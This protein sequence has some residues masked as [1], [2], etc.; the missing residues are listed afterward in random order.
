MAVFIKKLQ[1][2]GTTAP[3]INV[4]GA[5]VDLED[6]TKAVTQNFETFYNA[7][8]G[9]WNKDQEQEAL[10]Q[11]NQFVNELSNG[12]ITNYTGPLQ[13]L[14]GDYQQYA[15]KVAQVVGIYGKQKEKRRFT[16]KSIMQDFYN[17][18]FGGS[19]EPDFQSFL[20]LDEVVTDASGQK[21]RGVKN[22]VNALLNFLNENYLSKY[23]DADESLGGIEGVRYKIDRL[24]SALADGK[25][26][27]EDYAAASALGFNLRGLLSGMEQNVSQ[28]PN[29]NDLLEEIQLWESRD[30]G[31]F[32]LN[33][34][35][36]NPIES[37]EFLQNYFKND[38]QKYATHLSNLAKNLSDN[39]LS[40]YT[41]ETLS[42]SKYVKNIPDGTF[43][44]SMLDT[45]TNFRNILGIPTYQDISG[46]YCVLPNSFDQ[47]KGTIL[48]YYPELKVLKPI[49]IW[50]SENKEL[51][52]SYYLRKHPELAQQ[53]QKGQYG[54]KVSND[55]PQYTSAEQAFI[56]KYNTSQLGG[57]P[58]TQEQE[59][60][61]IM[62]Q[63]K[64][65]Q[66]VPE[67]WGKKEWAE[68]VSIASSLAA[69]ADPEPFSAA[70]LGLNGTLFHAYN[71]ANDEDGF[72]LGDAG[73]TL[74]N[75]GFDV[76]GAIPVLGDFAQ[77]K[78]ITK[79]I[80][81]LGAPLLGIMGATQIP[82]A[83]ES[84]SKLLKEGTDK[85][86]VQDWRN[87][88]NGLMS[89]LGAKNYWT[90][91]YRSRAIDNASDF[92][93]KNSLQQAQYDFHSILRNAGKSTGK[94][95]GE[96]TSWW[97]SFKNSLSPTKYYEQKFGSVPKQN[98]ESPS[99]IWETPDWIKNT[100][101]WIKKTVGFK[102]SG[103][104]MK[105][106]PGGWFEN[107]KKRYQQQSLT[108]WDTT[109]DQSR[110]GQNLRGNGHYN[111]G[112]LQEAYNRNVAYIDDFDAVGKDLQDY[113]NS[114][115]S[116]NSLE[117]YVNNYNSDI[118]KLTGHW[119]T[120]RIYGSMDARDHNRLFRSMYTRRSSQDSNS[121]YNIG[122]QDDIE[123]IEGSSAWLRRADNYENLWDKTSL[124]DKLRRIHKIK[125]GNG[126]EG[127]VYKENNGKIGIIGEQQVKDLINTYTNNQSPSQPNMPSTS[128]GPY[129][130]SPEGRD[131]NRDNGLWEKAAPSLI[132]LQRLYG[133]IKSSNNRTEKY[134]NSLITPSVTPPKFYR[135]VYGDYG[136]MKHYEDQGA[137]VN[138]MANRATTSNSKL[139]FLQRL[140]GQNKANE[141]ATQGKLADNEKIKET[142]ELSAKQAKENVLSEVEAANKNKELAAKMAQHKAETRAYTDAA[143]RQSF[144]TY[145]QN[146]IE[147]PI[148]Q[149]INE[150]RAHQ[151]IF[152]NLQL[153][154]NLNYDFESDQEYQKLIYDYQDAI[155]SGDQVAADRAYNIALQYRKSKQQD[156]YNETLDYFRRMKRL[157][158]R[159]PYTTVYRP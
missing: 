25:L 104:V 43:I 92:I 127:Y 40:Y 83:V 126:Q 132:A 135:Q 8:K 29:N 106:E 66:S 71:L 87:I 151:D 89:I 7:Y 118:D 107:Y 20:D 105:M 88:A 59:N 5:K 145:H 112:S 114:S 13:N 37:S 113:Y 129:V 50:K 156:K 51:L 31:D 74:L 134:L 68:I 77:A 116:N 2:G 22:R 53:I 138:S 94:P 115:Y 64:Y 62:D 32:N 63:Q 21:V 109:K 99:P 124:E 131:I 155:N 95:T 28:K 108:G 69:I 12:Q 146:Y 6:F 39:G 48:A 148:T 144:D 76:A 73:K 101:N 67:T 61:S 158:Q 47:N 58:I 142:G 78:K 52:Q 119:S 46:L 16:N 70:A 139:A 81:N 154:Q 159:F 96:S 14:S 102:K 26:D 56:Q 9:I 143:N 136:L 36:G 54:F 11:H 4:Y 30:N 82:G 55:Q 93:P 98:S 10:R 111:A 128:S 35:S 133:D 91:K 38:L 140:E 23:D 123:D 3:K 72:T 79:I 65:L 60:P 120:N 27:N 97:E 75:A 100:G 141:L 150:H 84:T 153:Q 17:E 90:N 86:T 34:G 152:D 19:T 149:A 103:G 85:M 130:E 125:L 110:A 157:R 24:R 18:F 45:M 33:F 121:P 57:E 44:Q 49:K 1:Q 15:D 117:D 80:K 41:P 137:Q 147:A 122:Y 42:T